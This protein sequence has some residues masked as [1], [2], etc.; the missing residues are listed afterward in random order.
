MSNIFENVWLLLTVAG[1]A[2]VI[3][4]I[5]RQAKPEWGYW[6]L[7]APLAIAALAFGLDAM[8]KT[9]TEAINEI[10]ARSKQAAVSGS[11]Q[12]LMT[13]ISP[14]Y[15]D[16]AHRNRETFEEQAGQVLRNASVKKIKTQSHLLTLNDNTAKSQLNLVVHFHNDSRYAAMGTLMFVSLNLDYEKI[17]KDWFI[18]SA[19]VVSVNNQPYNW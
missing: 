2:L 4:S 12:M 6:P 11:V 15:S 16:R 14:R 13:S 1:V 19:E 10:I 18:R 9:D 3:V 7:L 8:I 5:I 17:G